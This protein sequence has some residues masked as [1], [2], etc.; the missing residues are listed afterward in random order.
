MRKVLTLTC[1]F[2]MAAV[3]S[4][5]AVEARP[6]PSIQASARALAYETTGDLIWSIDNP[7]Y[8]ATVSGI[9]VIEGWVLSEVG[10]SR[11]DL[12]VDGDYVSTANINIPRDDVI[13][14]YPQFADTPSAHP[15][16]T[17]GFVASDYT[18]GTH[19]LHLV[20]TDSND[21]ATAIGHRAVR[22]SGLRQRLWGTSPR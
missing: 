20:V 21:H 5:A 8:Q 22:V 13:E 18:N 6:A 11:I 2:L 10:V 12:Y 16:F 3:F 17:L 9:V 19:Y 14:Q 15:G 7:N 1:L 4:L